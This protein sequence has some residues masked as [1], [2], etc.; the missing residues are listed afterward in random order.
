M[1]NVKNHSAET[2]P[3]DQKKTATNEATGLE[4]SSVC[5]E[6]YKLA[7]NKNGQVFIY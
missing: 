4:S 5:K 7:E 1:R 6:V 3:L 2:R